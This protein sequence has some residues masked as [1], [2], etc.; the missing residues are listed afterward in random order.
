M[1][2]PARMAPKYNENK[3]ISEK[4]KTY[5][6]C[7][8]LKVLSKRKLSEIKILLKHPYNIFIKKLH[9]LFPFKQL[10]I[11]KKLACNYC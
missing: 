4:I 5:F 7:T 1:S 9:L 10:C 11:R 8:F 3:I 6:S 2:Y